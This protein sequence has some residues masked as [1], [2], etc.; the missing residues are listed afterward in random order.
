[1]TYP[2]GIISEEPGQLWKV[3]LRGNIGQELAALVIAAI[4]HDKAD[5][6]LSEMWVVHPL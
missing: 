4:F 6:H 3:Q 1:M 5:L 2:S